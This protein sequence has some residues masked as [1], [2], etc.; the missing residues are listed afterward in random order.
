[1]SILEIMIAAVILF[2]ILTGV[3]G[4]VGTT[5]LMGVDA[6][7]R[8]VMV[9]ALNAYVEKVQSL[10]FASVA[11]TTG[12]GALASEETTTVG[13]FTVTIRPTIAAGSN[14][15]LK[16]L[17][18]VIEVTAPG[19]RSTSFTTTVPIR[20]RAQFLTQANRTPETDPTIAFNDAYTPAQGA[21][22]WGTSCT[23][24]TGVL[25]IAADATASDGRLVNAVS[26]W[27]DDSYYAK[28]SADEIASWSPASQTFSVSD[29]V[30]NT[31][32][33]EEVLQGD[34]SYLAVPII[35]DG[36]R[37]VVAR[38][39][40][41]EQIAVFT[42]RQLLV[43]NYAPGIPTID[44]TTTVI[45][46]TSITNTSATLTWPVANDGTTPADHYEVRLFRHPLG[47]TGPMN[48]FEHWP[49]VSVGTPTENSLALTSLTAFSR[50][51]PVV[52]ALSP[53]NLASEYTTGAPLFVTR[54]LITGTYK[55]E[56]PKVAGTDPYVFTSTLTCSVPTFPASNITYKWYRVDPT[57]PG[58]IEVVGTG[59]TLTADVY[60]IQMPRST[61]PAPPVKYYCRVT[62][63]PLGVAGGPSV[64]LSNTVVTTATGEVATTAYGVGT[65]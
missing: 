54:P 49:E 16:S 40:D 46:A 36:M 21:V 7:Q 41:D 58:G 9:N 4:L 53:R 25:K 11:L 52:R 60:S 37:S 20:D 32:Q 3:L 19:R 48:P 47:D 38:V 50:Y 24:A 12:G 27:I 57:N 8:N 61:D 26:F 43:D 13:E 2:I 59:Q 44:G 42:V 18:V 1:M 5:T 15:S 6:K 35:A 63:T 45:A 22:V 14:D 51:Y 33:T 62:F 29:F 30:W 34:G 28:D 23:G 10:P 65:W 17:T 31:L 56:S 64:V 39:E 55:I